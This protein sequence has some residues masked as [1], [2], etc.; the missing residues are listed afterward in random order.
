MPNTALSLFLS[1]LS[2]ITTMLL[3]RYM[4]PP[5]WQRMLGPLFASAGLF[6]WLAAG[7]AAHRCRL[8]TAR[9]WLVL[10]A[11]WGFFLLLRLV[12]PPILPPPP[13]PFVEI[14]T[15]SHLDWHSLLFQWAPFPLFAHA[16]IVF[17]RAFARELFMEEGSLFALVHLGGILATLPGVVQILLPL[18]FWFLVPVLFLAVTLPGITVFR[19]PP[20]RESNRFSKKTKT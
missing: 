6:V 4:D 18:D 3:V 10:A 8:A 2:L 19:R 13:D 1:F 5:W 9:P 15:L 11:G 14:P 7:H 17:S 16:L 12:F 20:P